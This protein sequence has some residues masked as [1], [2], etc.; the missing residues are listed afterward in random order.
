MATV[1]LTA[2]TIDGV[3]EQPGIMLL[4][5]WAEWCGP[6]KSFAPIYEEAS[7]RHPDVT[8]AKVDVEAQPQV[9]QAF[10]IMA[11]PTLMA[12]RDGVIVFNQPGSV[13]GSA[14]DELITRVKGLDMD[15]VTAGMP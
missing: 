8:F 2:E 12:V 10:Q 13:P 14:L 9:A 5:F 6:C 1:A 4:D 15:E 3:L 11:V 7:Q